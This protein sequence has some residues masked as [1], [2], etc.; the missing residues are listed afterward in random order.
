MTIKIGDAAVGQDVQVMGARYTIVRYVR[1][2]TPAYELHSDNALP[3]ERPRYILMEARSS[4]YYYIWAE[5]YVRYAK[6]LHEARMQLL[7]D[8]R[9]IRNSKA[10]GLGP[11]K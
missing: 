11:V 1:A 3:K 5:T 10:L 4:Q 2:G 6:P 7:R 9:M 8:I